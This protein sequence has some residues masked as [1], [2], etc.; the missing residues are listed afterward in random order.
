MWEILLDDE[1]DDIEECLHVSFVFH[2]DVLQDLVADVFLQ[3]V[4]L[5]MSLAVSSGRPIA[6]D[7]V[8]ETDYGLQLQPIIVA[9][10]EDDEQVGQKLDGVGLDITE[11]LI[12]I[13]AQV[14]G[15][16]GV[17]EAEEAVDDGL[18]IGLGQRF[19]SLY[20]KRN[21]IWGEVN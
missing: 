19:P 12:G 10:L 1:P 14:W 9:L 17:E 6:L 4:E 5:R 15:G 7:Y 8:A 21:I 11:M 18:L 3:G 16:V 2:A 20:H 13:P